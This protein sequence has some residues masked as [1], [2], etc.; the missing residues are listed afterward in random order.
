MGSAANASGQDAWTARD[1]WKCIG[2]FF[3]FAFLTG[4]VIGAIRS[5]FPRFYAWSRHALG[6]FILYSIEDMIIILT[7]L[8]FARMESMR[9]FW[10]AFALDRPPSAYAWFA[11]VAALLIRAVSHLLIVNG[12]SRGVTILPIRG[13]LRGSGAVRYLYLVPLFV[14][15]FVE[16]IFLRGFLYRAFRGSY[17]VGASIALVVALTALLHSD[18]F[19]QSWA[20][21]VFISILTILLCA[22]REQSD[23]L[24]DCILCHFV[25]NTTAVFASILRHS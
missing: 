5:E 9:S 21:A 7:T 6:Y 2:M 3:V 24:W 18:Q 12:L 13:F 16:E 20:A 14:A 25:F 8:Y 10:K 23:S 11:I 19:T 15:P 4:V 17:T 22:L 1:A